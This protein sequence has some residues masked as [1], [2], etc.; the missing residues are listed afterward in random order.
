M[1]LRIA[2]M[3]FVLGALEGCSSSRAALPSCTLWDG[4]GDGA[5]AGSQC[6]TP[7]L[8]TSYQAQGPDGLC[9]PV[10]GGVCVLPCN[11]SADCAVLGSNAVCYTCSSI[12][13]AQGFCT[14]FQ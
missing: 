8:C 9:H 7:F 6:A 3:L 1:R 2:A 5:P 11:S 4:G 12:A 10:I 14:A 13:A